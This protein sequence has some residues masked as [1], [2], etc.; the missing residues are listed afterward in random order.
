MKKSRKCSQR[1]STRNSHKDTSTINF[2]DTYSS[3][4]PKDAIFLVLTARDQTS[5]LTWH[6]KCSKKSLERLLVSASGHLVSISSE[7]HFFGTK[8]STGST[9]SNNVTVDTPYSLQQTVPYLK[10]SAMVSK[11]VRKLYGR[12][13]PRRKSEKIFLDRSDQDSEFDSFGKRL[14]PK[15]SK[16]GK[17]GKT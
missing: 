4:Q 13:G 3:K 5:L 11:N 12:I 15:N 17:N 10:D 7:N 6:L 2:Q 16:G 14:P 1:G 8:S 9:S